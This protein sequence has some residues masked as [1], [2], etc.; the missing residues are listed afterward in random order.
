MF[1]LIYSDLKVLK[2]QNFGFGKNN[3]DL[4]I[5]RLGFGSNF[6]FDGLRGFKFVNSKKIDLIFLN[7]FNRL[8]KNDILKFG[9]FFNLNLQK[10]ILRRIDFLKFNRS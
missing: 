2:K 5:R 8:L 6:F 7:R 4:C 3:Q 10:K 1:G 9:T